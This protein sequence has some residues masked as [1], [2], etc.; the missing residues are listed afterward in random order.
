MMRRR[1]LGS[2]VK[3]TSNDGGRYDYFGKSVVIG[4]DTNVVGAPHID[5]TDSG[6]G[7]VYV[8]SGREIGRNTST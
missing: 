5:G 7:Y 6:R 8:R 3:L 1:T 2:Q 4:R